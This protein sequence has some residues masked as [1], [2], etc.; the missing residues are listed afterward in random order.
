MMT[1]QVIK[2][3]VAF[4]WFFVGWLTLGEASHH[5]VRAP[6]SPAEAG[7]ETLRPL[8]QPTLHKRAI[9]NSDPLVLGSLQMTAALIDI[10]TETS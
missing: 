2:D 10:L 5:V 9:L 8:Q 6:R 1:I 7:E 3:L 4:T